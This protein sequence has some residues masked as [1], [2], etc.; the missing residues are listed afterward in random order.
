[1]LMLNLG[2]NSTQIFIVLVSVRKLTRCAKRSAA[3]K[4]EK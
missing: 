4:E 3:D 2:L 1:M